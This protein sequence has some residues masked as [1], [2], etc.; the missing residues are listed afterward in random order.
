MGKSP[1]C[2]EPGFKKGPWTPEEDLK[3]VQYVQQDGPG[4]WRA[5]PKLAGLNRCGKSCRLRWTNYVRP[6]IK[7]GNISQEEEQIDHSTSPFYPRK[8]MGIDP[9]TH[10]PRIDLF[11]N[12]QDLLPLQYQRLDQHAATTLH[13]AAEA[14]AQLVKL[15]YLHQQYVLQSHLLNSSVGSYAPPP[16]KENL[17]VLNSSQLEND[18]SSSQPLPLWKRISTPSQQPRSPFQYF[19]ST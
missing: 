7:R 15:Q 5:V 16:I 4:S 6:D 8:Q 17:L 1:C 11:A 9:M 14:V 10:Q 19:C 3:L 18:S 12:L 13:D 2:D